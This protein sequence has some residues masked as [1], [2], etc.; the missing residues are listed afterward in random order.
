[1]T[2]YDI[3]A[4]RSYQAFINEASR[5]AP[6]QGTKNVYPLGSRKYSM[7]HWRLRDDGS[8]DIFYINRQ[9]RDK[10]ENG[11]TVEH[12][13]YVEKR[14]LATVYPDNTV[15]FH[16]IHGQGDASM[17]GQVFGVHIHH[18]SRKGG[19]VIDTGGKSHPVLEGARYKMDDGFNTLHPY[20]IF[21]RRGNRK[22]AKKAF[23]EYDDFIKAAPV[24]LAQMDIHGMRDAY[25]DVREKSF[26]DVLKAGHYVDA[27]VLLTADAHWA[28]RWALQSHSAGESVGNVIRGF[29]F[30]LKTKFIPQVLYKHDCFDY[31]EYGMGQ[32]KS[33]V[34]KHRIIMNG[35]QAKQL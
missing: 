9:L 17:L 29:E 16:Y 1:M 13:T 22:L 23:S 2:F 34:W 3:H 20:T 10:Y 35:V 11:K 24:M 19:T 18:V 7:R 33:S 25:N 15:Q 14:R 6:Y 8:I 12:S 30:A 5:G 27:A 4:R 31:T 26:M 28:A 32:L 21:Q